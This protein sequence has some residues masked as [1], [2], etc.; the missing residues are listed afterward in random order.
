MD[1]DTSFS[2]GSSLTSYP[3]THPMN[4]WASGDRSEDRILLS[5]ELT[6]DSMTRLDSVISTHWSCEGMAREE[7]GV[8]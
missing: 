5:I 8:E 2:R 7:V 6:C 1:E 4:H 3:L